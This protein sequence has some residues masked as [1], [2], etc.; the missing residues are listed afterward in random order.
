MVEI[1][2]SEVREIK[3]P[4]VLASILSLLPQLLLLFCS[5]LIFV[6]KNKIT[7]PAK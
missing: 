1:D 3:K 2:K 5:D 7:H 4:D 6:I